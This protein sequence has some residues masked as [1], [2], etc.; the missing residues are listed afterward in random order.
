MVDNKLN[1]LLLRSVQIDFSI[2]ERA[3]YKNISF[4]NIHLQLDEGSVCLNIEEVL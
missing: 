1:V 2:Y 3:E 4:C